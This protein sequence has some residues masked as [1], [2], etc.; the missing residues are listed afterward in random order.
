M[1]KVLDNT[2]AGLAVMFFQLSGAVDL[3]T[4][5]KQLNIPLWTTY[6][7]VLPTLSAQI[8]TN[9]SAQ[10]ITAQFNGDPTANVG[11]IAGC[12]G[13]YNVWF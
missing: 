5:V 7:P 8:S 9:F 11:V 2:T 6:S 10:T 13:L 1:T 3:S 4:P 12:T